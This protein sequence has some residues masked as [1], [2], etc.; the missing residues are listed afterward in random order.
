MSAPPRPVLTT[1]LRVIAFGLTLSIL[2]AALHDVSRAW[3]VW[4][5]HMPFAARIWGIV[6]EAAFSFHPVNQARY[7][8]FPLLAEVLQGLFWRV[9]GQPTTANLVAF[10]CLP[11]LAWF[12]RR[13]FQVPWHLTLIALLAIPLV[14][15]H[16]SSAYIDLPAN[17]AA[18]M[19]VLLVYHLHATRERPSGRVLAL[20]LALAAASANMRFQHHVL[21]GLSLLALAPPILGPIRGDLRAGGE[22]RRRAI[23]TLAAITL[24]LPIVFTSP[25]KNLVLHHNPYYPLKLEVAGI[26]LPGTEGVYSSS[27]PYLEHASRPQRFLYSILEIGIR[28]L[29][30]GSRWSIDQYMPP[31]SDG[32]R[33]GGYF[34]AYVVFQ[35]ALLGVTVMRARDR[36]AKVAGILFLALTIVT[37]VMPQSHEL[38]YYLYWMIVLVALNLALACRPEASGS[39]LLSPAALGVACAVALGIVLKVTEAGYAYPS[40]ST[41]AEL[42]K[43]RTDKAILDQIGEGDRVCIQKDPYN[44]LYASTFHPG[45]HYSVREAEEPSDC[46]D[47]RLIK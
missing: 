20:A 13:F 5:Y 39:T 33:M 47:H 22:P 4:Y 32:T 29:S 24:A 37:S 45:K 6:P 1:I 10:S 31:D 25:L 17:T 43:D 44:I 40:G 46:G 23:L 12:L 2:A 30:S 11:L 9:T 7:S 14:H 18:A 42:V 41:F 21:V 36:R 38:R 8:G 16:A 34:G 15:L 35:L 3:D 19:L 27:P 26:S 28:P